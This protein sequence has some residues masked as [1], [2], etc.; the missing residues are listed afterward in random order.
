MRNKGKIG[1]LVLQGKIVFAAITG[2]FAHAAVSTFAQMGGIAEVRLCLRGGNGY[3]VF[4]S[5]FTGIAHDVFGLG[6]GSIKVEFRGGH[7]G[8][9]SVNGSVNFVVGILLQVGG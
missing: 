5:V 6:K 3:F 9:P 8:R 7:L 2:G 1:S 4:F